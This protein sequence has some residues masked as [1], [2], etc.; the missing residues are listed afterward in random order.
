MIEM[1]YKHCCVI[2]KDNYY[3]T[4]VLVTWPDFL[5]ASI[6]IHAHEMAEGESLL[7]TSPPTGMV[8]ARWMGEAWEETAT[9]EEVEAAE[10]KRYEEAGLPWPPVA[11]EP[12]KTL[13]D[14]DEELTLTQLG[15]AEAF[16]K[17]LQAQ[18]DAD[19]ALLGIVEIY[20]MIG[21]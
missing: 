3:V 18:A 9:P 2:D 17:A 21:G 14:L 13:A 20:E 11:P 16:E 5:P 10:R 8:K 19:T 1:G 12:Q 4:Y 15:I 7:G 6:K